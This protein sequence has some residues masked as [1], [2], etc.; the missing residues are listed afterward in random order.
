MI[1]LRAAPTGNIVAA[2]ALAAIMPIGRVVLMAALAVHGAVVFNVQI[3][4]VFR[5]VAVEA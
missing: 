3:T 4:P 1:H 5:R 2:N